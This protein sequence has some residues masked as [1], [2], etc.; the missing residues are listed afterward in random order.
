MES[1]PSPQ[2]WHRTTA[3]KIFLT[4]L[5]SFGVISVLFT[6]MTGY[7]FWKINTGQ[8]LSLASKFS[9][10]FSLDPS[11]QYLN[12]SNIVEKDLQTFVHDYSPILGSNEAP[13]T[14]L[15]FIDFECPFC[16]AS[17]PIFKEITDRYGPAIRVV[18]KHLP[19]PQLHPLATRAHLASA[20][21]N[22]QDQFWEY[23]EQLF[24]QND[25]SKKSLVEYAKTLN[26][27]MVEFES[28][29]SNSAHESDIE[30]DLVDAADIAVRGTPTYVV[31][32]IRLEGV[33]P[34]EVWDEIILR[35]I[36]K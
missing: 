29:L 11:R 22:D 31:N 21:A 4:I 26:L 16:R 34:K 8:G 2:K 12:T 10:Q 1:Q 24:V 36:R 32:G 3:G 6:V 18:F 33:V 7:Y 28:C 14:I 9:Q 25:L 17:F 20:C 19:V 13:V 27:D 35:E 30:Q 15:A 5:L 23:Y